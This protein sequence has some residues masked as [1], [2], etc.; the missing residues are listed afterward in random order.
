MLGRC[1]PSIRPRENRWRPNMARARLIPEMGDTLAD[2]LENLGDVSPERIPLRPPPGTATERDVIAARKTPERWLFE[3]A[4]GVL[5]LK[6]PG[7]AQSV[8]SGAV[9]HAVLSY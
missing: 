7:F 6:P 8:L 3:L 4:D 1:R 9:A 2:L 5:I